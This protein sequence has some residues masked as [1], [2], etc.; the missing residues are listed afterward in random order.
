MEFG[1]VEPAHLYNESVLR[2]AKQLDM[3]EKLNLGKVKDPIIS[4]LEM[5]Y[6]AEF[7]GTVPA[8]RWKCFKDKHARIKDF[9]VRYI[10]LLSQST[11]FQTFKQICQ[12]VLTVAFS[13]TEDIET[14]DDIIFML[15]CSTTIDKQ[16]ENTRFGI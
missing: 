1:N 14:N 3:D 4:V 10:G 9:F 6:K 13:E 11:T 7:S 12:D 5:K 2:K 16:N 15:Q 8:C